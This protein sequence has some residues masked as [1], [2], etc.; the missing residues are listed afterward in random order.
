MAAILLVLVFAAAF[1]WDARRRRAW[2][3]L[4]TK[5]RERWVEDPQAPEWPENPL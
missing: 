5:L 1:W 3:R 2:K 4:G